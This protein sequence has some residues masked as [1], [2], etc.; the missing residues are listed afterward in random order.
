M[1][2]DLS[3]SFLD[4]LPTASSKQLNAMIEAAQL[5]LEKRK[6]QICDL[7]TY[8]PDFCKDEEILTT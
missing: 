3:Q 5:E 7:V 6:P 1:T 4:M 8:L 2:T